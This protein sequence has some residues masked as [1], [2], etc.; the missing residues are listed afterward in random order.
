MQK[1]IAKNLEIKARKMMGIHAKSFITSLGH[2][3]G[4]EVHERPYISA[5][6]NDVLKEGMVFTIEPGFY[7]A[8][9]LRIENDFVLT[10]DGCVNITD[11]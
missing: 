7:K 4:I 3:I 8:G 5:N 9:G 10:K 1:D 2:G 11:F 6:S